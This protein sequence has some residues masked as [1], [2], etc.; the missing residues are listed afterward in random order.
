MVSLFYKKGGQRTDFFSKNKNVLKVSLKFW[1]RGTQMEL[2][3][4]RNGTSESPTGMPRE[5]KK[6]R[7]HF[8]AFRG[9]L[10]IPLWGLFLHQLI[11]QATQKTPKATY[12]SATGP[13][14]TA[15]WREGRRQLVSTKFG[16]KNAYL[17]VILCVGQKR[18]S[19]HQCDHP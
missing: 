2:Q 13:Q 6:L 1:L 15:Q 4:H 10:W 17:P 18:A 11:P 7:K 19:T 16:E 12:T 5:P 8:F 3:G 9:G 14:W